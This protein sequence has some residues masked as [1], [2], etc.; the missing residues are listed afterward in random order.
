MKN[1]LALVLAILMIALLAACDPAEQPARP[2]STDSAESAQTPEPAA[3]EEPSAQK[4]DP[5]ILDGFIDDGQIYFDLHVASDSVQNFS[6]KVG[7]ETLTESG[8]IPF[9]ADDTIVLNGEPAEGKKFTMYI[10][11]KYSNEGALSIE[12]FVHIGVRAD[13]LGELLGKIYQRLGVSTTKAYVTVLETNDGWNHDLSP[14]LNDYLNA[15][16]PAEQ[17]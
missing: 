4:V 6:L 16:K 10:I 12:H 14:K 5:T 3:S 9:N 8:K 7:N 1:V 11:R 2:S 17:K 15:I 13:K